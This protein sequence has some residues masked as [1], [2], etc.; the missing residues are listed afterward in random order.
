MKKE[1]TVTVASSVKFSDIEKRLKWSVCCGL[2]VKKKKKN[3]FLTIPF[4]R[5]KGLN[6]RLHYFCEEGKATSLIDVCVTSFVTSTVQ[7]PFAVFA[8]L[9]KNKAHS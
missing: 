8:K 7:F 9:E 1:D 6:S 3:L 4:L 5:G 2:A